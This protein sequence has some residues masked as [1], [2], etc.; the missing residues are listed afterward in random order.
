MVAPV[1]VLVEGVPPVLTLQNGIG[2]AYLAVVGAAVA[3][4]L[5]FRGIERVGGSATSFLAIL[6]PLTAAVAGL[7]VLGQG[8]TFRQWTGFGIALA[9]VLAA[10]LAPG[11]RR[12]QSAARQQPAAG[13]GANPMGVRALLVAGPL[14]RDRG[15]TGSFLSRHRQASLSSLRCHRWQRRAP[16]RG[17]R[18][19]S[20]TS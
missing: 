15:V 11:G 7:L 5:W 10:Q 12:V 17:E 13:T 16:H 9:S 8:L 20:S 3:Y 18:P 2:Y 1:A 4:F 6:S 14:M 19:R